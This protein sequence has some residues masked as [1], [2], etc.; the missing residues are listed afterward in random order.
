MIQSTHKVYPGAMMQNKQMYRGGQRPTPQE[1]LINVNDRLG[2]SGIARQQGTSRIIYD[3][4]PLDGNTEMRFFENSAQRSFP[5]TNM[6]SFGNKLEVGESLVVQRAYVA[7]FSLKE[8]GVVSDLTDFAGIGEPGLFKSE[9]RLTIANQQVLKPIPLT[10]FFSQFNKYAWHD[11]ASTFFFDTELIIPPLLE[12]NWDLRL[13]P[14]VAIE[15]SFVQLTIEGVGAIIS[16]RGT[17]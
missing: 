4:L 3:S 11:S 8:D 13:P 14:Y 7:V 1:K 6:G 17:L 5:L 2:N 12:F 10:S 16:T 9:L 15:E